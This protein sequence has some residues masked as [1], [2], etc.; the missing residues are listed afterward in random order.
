MGTGHI[1]RCIALAQAWQ[2][3][4]GSVTL[5]A[6]EI[7]EPLAD[8]VRR[9]GIALLPPELQRADID[10][11]CAA[12]EQADWVVLDGYQFDTAYCTALCRSAARVLFVDDLGQLEHYPSALVLNQNITADAATYAQHET[13]TGLLLGG[14]YA[15]LR[16]EFHSPAPERDAAAA[17]ERVLVTLGGS[18]PDNVTAKVIEVLLTLPRIHARVI[19]GAA[20]PRRE[21]LAALCLPSAGRIELLPPVEN[22]VPLMDGAQMA[23]SAGG[24]SVLEL[25]S[26]GLPA[27]LIAIADNQLAICQMMRE[28]GVMDY[29][30]WHQ[31]VSV[32]A[33]AAAVASLS[34][35]GAAARRARFMEQGRA[36]VDGRG[37]LR[38]A[39]EMMARSAAAA[40]SVRVA[41]MDDARAVL[42]WANDPVTRSVSFM[43][44]QIEWETHAAWFARRLADSAGCRLLIGLDQVGQR[45]G[46]VRFDIVDGTAT[47]SINVAPEHRGRGLGTA[48]ILVAC[49]ELL[50]G[51]AAREIRALIKPDN[52]ASRIA[53]Q[54][55]G[56]IAAADE[57]VAGQCA[58]C[59]V[60]N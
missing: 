35:A 27:L 40:V 51:D 48:L 60:L 52:A 58:L 16:R 34:E 37:A 23:I 29:V 15:L 32:Q 14:R 2:D 24:T 6:R 57:V 13:G 20:N 9:E 22:M 49:H 47:I 50:Q 17:V 43:Q 18:D 8:R 7:P 56:F 30:G 4:G 25:A 41:T 45:L 26:R 12:A 54:R 11:T 42:D 55:A 59:M 36:M 19:L 53:F 5:L 1:M 46:M 39:R 38:V 10:A 28:R 3:M 21:S 44:T 31:D 33:L